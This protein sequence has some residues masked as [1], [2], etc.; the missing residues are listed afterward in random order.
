MYGDI[1]LFCVSDY[2]PV[3]ST[4]SLVVNYCSF[5]CLVARIDLCW[6]NELRLSLS[7]GAKLIMFDRNKFQDMIKSETLYEY[8]RWIWNHKKKHLHQMWNK[9]K[10][11]VLHGINISDSLWCLIYHV[12]G[13]NC[14]CYFCICLLLVCWN[15]ESLIWHIIS[16]DTFGWRPKQCCSW[17]LYDCKYLEGE[18]SR[19]QNKLK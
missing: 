1:I 2:K 16:C 11:H 6:K 14:H 19:V 4:M 13:F 17:I 3:L 9:A 5:L 8:E 10:L 7:N 12:D 15:L 18:H